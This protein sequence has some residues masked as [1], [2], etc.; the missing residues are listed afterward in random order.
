M[1]WSE[2]Q[3]QYPDQFVL[4]GDIVEEKISETRYRIT[5][6]KVLKVS[7]DAKKIRE[8][9]QDYRKKD[10]NVIYSLPSTP[11]D[12]IVE[13]VPFRGILK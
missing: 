9:Y 8:A 3:R 13:N 5:E 11:P 4:L 6:G 12:F 1:K 2:I 7:D 10:M